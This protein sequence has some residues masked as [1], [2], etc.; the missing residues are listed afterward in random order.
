MEKDKKFDAIFDDNFI[1][2]ESFYIILLSF[3]RFTI[4]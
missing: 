1:E 4:R 3:L 2:F